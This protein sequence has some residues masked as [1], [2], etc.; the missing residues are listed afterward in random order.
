MQ[1]HSFFRNLP[2]LISFVDE[3]WLVQENHPT[4]KLDSK[5]ALLQRKHN[6]TVKSANLKENAGKGKSVVVMRAALYNKPNSKP[7]MT[8][9]RLTEVSVLKP[10]LNYCAS[11]C[12]PPL[13]PHSIPTAQVMNAPMEEVYKSSWDNSHCQVKENVNESQTFISLVFLPLAQLVLTLRDI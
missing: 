3:L 9:L 6:E 13:N 11:K 4:V 5:V 1:Q 10:S 12:L 7:M 8:K 2:P